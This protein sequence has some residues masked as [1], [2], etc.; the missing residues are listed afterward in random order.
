[1]DDLSKEQAHKA[2]LIAQQELAQPTPDLAKCMRFL[3]KCKKMDPQHTSV[4]SLIHVCTIRM[5]ENAPNVDDDD[6]DE[7]ATSS[8][9]P[10]ASP[11]YTQQQVDLI[12]KIMNNNS[13][14]EILGV[15]PNAS[16]SE[17]K[18]AYKKLGM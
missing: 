6:D 16:A 3:Q 5:D 1:M 2:F 11:V 15:H 7:H 12:A 9:P 18:A 13:H 17:T 4:D 8:P 14:Y 10:P